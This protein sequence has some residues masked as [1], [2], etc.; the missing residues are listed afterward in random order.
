LIYETWRVFS[1]LPST[2][3]TTELVVCFCHLSCPRRYG[4]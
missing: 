1:V 2:R 3:L 4:L